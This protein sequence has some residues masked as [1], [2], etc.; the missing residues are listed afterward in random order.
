MIW[1]RERRLAASGKASLPSRR[2][3]LPGE[4][5]DLWVKLFVA[6]FFSAVE[7][8]KRAVEIA[9]DEHFPLC[10]RYLDGSLH[11]FYRGEEIGFEEFD[12]QVKGLARQTKT[13]RRESSLAASGKPALPSPN[14]P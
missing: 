4:A 12:P 14:H 13:P 2:F 3:R 5:L 8:V 7:H 10:R 1:R 6:D 11:M 9:P